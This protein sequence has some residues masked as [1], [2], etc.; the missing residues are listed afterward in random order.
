M[1]AV[2]GA[3]P[4]FRMP[5]STKST[6]P[7]EQRYEQFSRLLVA[8]EAR[9]RSFLCSLL[10]TWTDV[11]EVMQETSLTAWRKFELFKL[12]SNFLAWSAAI[13]RFEALKHLRSRSRERLVFSSEVIDLVANDAA[14]EADTLERER[15]VLERCL[16]KLD[17]TSREFLELCFQPGV[18][19][20]EI[21]RRSGRG[22]EGFYKLIQRLR[23]R[24]IKC[25]QLE[26]KNEAR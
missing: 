21:A 3:T 1:E 7:Q 17:D 18:K 2:L 11:D 14:A 10:P 5:S 12:D 19:M 9:L 23:G 25:I 8:H 24:L 15:V 22:V 4:D 26:M 6:Q 13:A 16:A 20:H